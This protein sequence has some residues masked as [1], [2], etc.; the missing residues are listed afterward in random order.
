ML[1]VVESGL[2]VKADTLAR[3][4]RDKRWYARRMQRK[5]W[6][7]PTVLRKRYR[8]C[9]LRKKWER[10]QW[11]KVVYDDETTLNSA[12]GGRPPLARRPPGNDV[13]L[14]PRY[15]EPTFPYGRFS[16]PAYAAITFGAHTPLVFFRKRGEDE[17]KSPKD[18]LGVD[19]AQFVHEAL[20]SCLVPF[21]HSLPRS[22][23]D[24]PVI[25]DN[26]K[27]HTSRLANACRQAHGITRIPLPPSS[28]DLNP[29][30]NVWAQLKTRVRTRMRDPST[31]ARTE[32]EFMALAQREW[33]GLDW[34]A[35][36]LML[37]R[38]T[39]RVKAVISAR[40]GPTKY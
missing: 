12:S 2:E 37:D 28:P 38:M 31:R 20:E 14:N 3:K 22:A 33:E 29:I 26:A 27:I 18:K 11:Q 7:D 25:D 9:L 1:E 17:R 5:T 23:A 32:E 39:E 24:H 10:Q 13:A 4:L 36:Y 15:I 6:L 40:G 16:K 8:W 30:E 34:E 19:T 21:I 35:I